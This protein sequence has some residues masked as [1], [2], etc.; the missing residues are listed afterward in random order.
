MYN[1]IFVSPCSKGW[2]VQSASS[3]KAI[4]VFSQKNQAIARAKKVSKNKKSELFIQKKDGTIR[5]RISYGND[6]YPP[7]G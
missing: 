4:A 5:D 3:K 6:P 1:Q 7:E 2:K